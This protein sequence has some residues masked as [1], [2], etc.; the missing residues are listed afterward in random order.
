MKEKKSDIYSEKIENI[1]D[2]ALARLKTLIDVD[3]IIGNTILLPDGNSILP[4]SKINMGFV[5][6]A[7]E[8][9]DLSTK[10]L[11]KDYPTSAGIGGGFCVTPVGF[12][13]VNESRFELIDNSQSKLYLEIVKNTSEILKS[14]LKEEK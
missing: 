14:I 2:T 7:G 4:I 1:I 5:C 12:Y 8:Y 10:R 11:D 13:V 9:T 6:G 3:C